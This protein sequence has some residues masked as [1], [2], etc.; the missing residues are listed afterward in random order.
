LRDKLVILH[1]NTSKL[2]VAFPLNKP[3][4]TLN[5]YVISRDKLVILHDNT[6]ELHVAFHLNRPA[7]T[8]KTN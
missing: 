7:N 2:H 8:K 6:S 5:K 1:D 4:I 3:A